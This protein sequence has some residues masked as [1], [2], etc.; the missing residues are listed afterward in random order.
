LAWSKKPFDKPREHTCVSK[1]GRHVIKRVTVK[2]LT[3]V[4]SLT[5][6]SKGARSLNR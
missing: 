5:L 1:N 2:D 3:S 4:N 6:R